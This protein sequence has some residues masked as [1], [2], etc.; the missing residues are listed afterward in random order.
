MMF[1]IFECQ[2]NRYYE[3][4]K[5]MKE[6]CGYARSVMYSIL[7]DDKYGHFNKYLLARIHIALCNEC[8]KSIS[9]KAKSLSEKHQKELTKKQRDYF[10]QGKI[11]WQ[12]TNRKVVLCCLAEIFT[13]KLTEFIEKILAELLE[14][15][16]DEELKKKIIYKLSGTNYRSLYNSEIIYKLSRM[17][18][19]TI[20]KIFEDFNKEISKI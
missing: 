17:A 2:T 18:A 15:I 12:K 16:E 14:E 11:D 10:N 20:F 8:G 9:M 5:S 4:S 3:R 6:F 19:R 13:E 7:L 1:Y